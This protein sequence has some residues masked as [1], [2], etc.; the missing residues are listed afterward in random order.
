[1]EKRRHE[2]DKGVIFTKR[3]IA[4]FVDDMILKSNPKEK[5]W[6]FKVNKEKT[7]E[8]NVWLNKKGL[9]RCPDIF[10]F[11]GRVWFDKHCKMDRIVK[12]MY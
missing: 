7:K 1:M 8:H 10:C 11:K 9:P 12:S 6:D 5:G 2:W 3:G 4:E